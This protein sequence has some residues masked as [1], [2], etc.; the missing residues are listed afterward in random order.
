MI[1]DGKVVFD[2]T[3]QAEVNR[4]VQERLAREQGKYADHEE[5]KG[6]EE[7][8]KAFGYAGTPKE[9]RE[10]IKAQREETQRQA[11]LVKLQ[12]QAKTQGISPELLAEMKELKKEL[13]ELKGERQVQKQAAEAKTKLEA[14]WNAQVKEMTEAHP[15]VDLEALPNDPKFT[16]FAKGKNLPLKELYEDFVDFVGETQAGAI[17]KAKSKEQRS[18]G[19]GKG[20]NSTGKNHGLSQDQ[21]NT[22]DQWNKQNPKM[23]M[24]YQQFADRL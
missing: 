19:S 24:S 12:E 18:T 6:I 11:E 13:S 10:T 2:E 20:A 16:K 3:E 7:E 22:V 23:K 14:N 8:L 4:V 9:I 1:V 17:A 21:M 15:D 5:Y